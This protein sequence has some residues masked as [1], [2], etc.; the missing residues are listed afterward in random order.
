[1]EPSNNTKIYGMD[2]YFNEIIDLYDAKKMPNKILFSGKEGLGKSTLAYHI[3][4]YIFSKDENFC[5]DKSKHTIN[6]K[7]ISFKLVQNGSHPNFFLIK[8]RDEKKNIDLL[9]IR[10]MI[11]YSNKSSFN[12]KPRLVLIDNVEK[13]NLNSVNA[14][15]KIVE[16]PNENFYFILINN[17]EKKVLSTLKSRCLT[18]KINFT[19]DKTI[20]VS[21]KLLDQ[22]LFDIINLDLI[23]YYNTPGE[24]VNLINFANEKKIDLK[25]NNLKSLLKLLISSNYYKKNNFVGSLIV[26]LIELYILK[27]YKVSETKNSVLKIY[28]DF[29]NRVHNMKKYN[30]DEESLFLEFKSKLLN[31]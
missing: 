23:S 25:N 14:L 28:H 6:T 12:N 17:S 21:N 29:I 4:N 13:L 24:I 10:E 27:E 18:F 19:F 31:E 1:M 11:E 20:S 9:Q 5:Y 2:E 7:N 22:N 15:L 30:L 16:E 8:L 26:N 3:I